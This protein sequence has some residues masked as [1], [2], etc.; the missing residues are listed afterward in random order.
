MAKKETTDVGCQKYSANVH[1]SLIFSLLS[2]S[3]DNQA[4]F[5]MYLIKAK[6]HTQLSFPLKLYCHTCGLLQWGKG[7]FLRRY[8]IHH[9]RG[10]LDIL[11][12]ALRSEFTSYTL[13]ENIDSQDGVQYSYQLETVLLYIF[14]VL[15]IAQPNYFNV[16]SITVD[17]LSEQCIL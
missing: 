4:I 5:G 14:V 15:T 6:H 11:V 13:A 8:F 1:A 2:M 10:F 12:Q 3:A 7:R 17:M 16:L 9:G